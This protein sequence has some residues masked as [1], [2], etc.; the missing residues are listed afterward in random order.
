MIEKTQKSVDEH[1]NEPWKNYSS[2]TVYCV[3]NLKSDKTKNNDQTIDSWYNDDGF[4]GFSIEELQEDKE[5]SC[6]VSRKVEIPGPAVWDKKRRKSRAFPNEI[7]RERKL[8]HFLIY[9]IN[10]MKIDLRAKVRATDV[11]ILELDIFHTLNYDWLANR[12]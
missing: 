7:F 9:E 1:V 10:T 6:S 4:M 3:V 11:G 2:N 12:A 5:N 8:I